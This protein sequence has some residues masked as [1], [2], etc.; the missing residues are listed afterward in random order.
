MTETTLQESTKLPAEQARIVP[1][2]TRE[3]TVSPAVD[4]YETADGHVLIADM[5]GIAQDDLDVRVEDGVLTIHG[6]VRRQ[7]R[8]GLVGREFELADYFR[9]F[10]L[11]EDVDQERISAE[12]KSGVLRLALPKAEKVKPRKIQVKVRE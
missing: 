7:C 3:N 2:A 5:P 8:E 10:K 9:Q 12:L 6:R 4:I 11:G 1:A